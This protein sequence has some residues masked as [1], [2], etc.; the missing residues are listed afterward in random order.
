MCD[1]NYKLHLRKKIIFQ[2]LKIS[3]LLFNSFIFN[4]FLEKP[5]AWII[6][7]AMHGKTNF[8]A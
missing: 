8:R 3:Y 4:T 7:D 6:H 2:N 1:G 5:K